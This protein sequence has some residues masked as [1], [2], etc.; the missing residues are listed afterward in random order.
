VRLREVNGEDLFEV[1]DLNV[2]FMVRC[3]GPIDLAGDPK[4][5]FPRT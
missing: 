4:R 3:H 5:T 2:G 1:E